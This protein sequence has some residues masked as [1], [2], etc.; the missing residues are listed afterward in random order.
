MRI[1]KIDFD[2]PPAFKIDGDGVF[3]VI[4][5]VFK[6]VDVLFFLLWV[7]ERVCVVK[8]AAIAG[9]H[10]RCELEHEGGITFVSVQP[11]AKGI[12]FAKVLPFA[13]C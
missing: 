11:E 8:R 9:S 2:E 1:A 6:N 3:V 13:L 12:V 7:N 5:E 4:C 10:A